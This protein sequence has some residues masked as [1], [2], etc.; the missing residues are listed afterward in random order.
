MMEAS[1]ISSAVRIPA[2]EGL[3]C[4]AVEEPL[5]TSSS[6]EL[7]HTTSPAQETSE[8]VITLVDSS[9]REFHTNLRASDL[10]YLVKY[11]I[12]SSLRTELRSHNR[13]QVCR[14]R[15]AHSTGVTLI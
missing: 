13:R 2:L 9:G 5:H 10:E 15:G 8:N 11:S 4:I 12:I 6:S 1:L 3:S 14:T 7:P